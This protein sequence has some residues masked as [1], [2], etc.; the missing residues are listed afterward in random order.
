MALSRISS[1]STA[2]FHYRQIFA[3]ALLLNIIS[4]SSDVTT[5]GIG[6]AIYVLCVSKGRRT[7]AAL[8]EQ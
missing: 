3:V 5:N 7:I 8:T 2:L 4:I 6:M 1:A